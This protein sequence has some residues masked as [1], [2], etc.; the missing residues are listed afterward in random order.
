MFGG[1]LDTSHATVEVGR[2]VGSCEACHPIERSAELLAWFAP[3]GGDRVSGIYGLE[4]E[5]LF[6]AWRGAC[7]GGRTCGVVSFD[8]TACL[9]TLRRQT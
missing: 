9:S 4:L 3:F 8:P 1:A 2:Y 7:F 6:V 5:Y